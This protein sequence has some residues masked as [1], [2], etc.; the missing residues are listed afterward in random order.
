MRDLNSMQQD[1]KVIAI[2]AAITLGIFLLAFRHAFYVS[3]CTVD[4]NLKTASLELTFRIFTDDLEKSLLDEY[5]VNL[6]LGA[7]NEHAK[8]DSLLFDYIKNSFA[9]QLDK[10]RTA[11]HFVGKEVE[12]DLT[13]IYLEIAVQKKFRLVKVSNRMLIDS[14]DSQKNIIHLNIHGQK[15][16]LLFHKGYDED[17]VE[18]S[19]QE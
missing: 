7:K 16:S 17:T 19:P 15:K 9:L 4:E 5:G 18:F 8:A 10:G 12:I 11:M 3:I 14:F 13:W 1:K 2:L 6:H